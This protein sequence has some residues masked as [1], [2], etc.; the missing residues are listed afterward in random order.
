MFRASVLKQAKHR[1]IVSLLGDC[2]GCRC[3]DLGGDNGV[4]SRA[5]RQ[6]GG[7]WSSADLDAGAVRSIAALVGGEV[8]LLK[9][10]RLPFPES[11]FDRVAVV[12]LL[13]HVE[14][15]ERLVGELRR[16]LRPGGVLVINVPHLQRRSVL[17]RVRDA[18]GLTDAWH[19]HLRPGYSEDGLRTLLAPW[20]HVTDV[21][22]YSRAFSETLDTALNLA[23]RLKQRGGGRKGTVVTLEDSGGTGLEARLLRRAY[24]LCRAFAGLDRLL[25]LQRGY[26]LAIRAVPRPP[27]PQ[28]QV[29]ARS[30]R[31]RAAQ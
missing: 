24:R 6:S 30:P 26:K 28:V 20:F 16:V 3:L 7:E 27:L 9:G 1:A 13:E 23:Y 19:G 31:L 15:D 5:L 18:V 22:P 4:I 2:K 8:H 11:S 29:V 12:D 10:P 14:D 17:N 21:Y 25:P